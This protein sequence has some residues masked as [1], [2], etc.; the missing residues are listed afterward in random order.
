LSLRLVLLH[1]PLEL[2]GLEEPFTVVVKVALVLAFLERGE[3]L[4][5]FVRHSVHF[6]RDFCALHRFTSVIPQ[7]LTGLKLSFLDRLLQ[8]AGRLREQTESPQQHD[9]ENTFFFDLIHA[10]LL[11]GIR[12]F[13]RHQCCDALFKFIEVNYAFSGPILLKDVIIWT[14]VQ[15]FEPP[16]VAVHSGLILLFIESSIRDEEGLFDH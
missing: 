4:L 14:G 10:K 5:R 12:R 1:R 11:R 2:L 3:L 9:A 7:A 16:D 8:L 15:I 13:S 6:E